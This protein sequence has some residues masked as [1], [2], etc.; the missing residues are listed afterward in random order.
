MVGILVTFLLC[1]LPYEVFLTYQTFNPSP[2]TSTS[3]R[4][5]HLTAYLFAMANTLMNPILFY[6]L[7]KEYLTDQLPSF[8]KVGRWLFILPLISNHPDTALRSATF[9]SEATSFSSKSTP[10]RKLPCR[11]FSLDISWTDPLP[12]NLISWCLVCIRVYQYRLL[13]IHS[14]FAVTL[15]TKQGVHNSKNLRTPSRKSE[16]NPKIW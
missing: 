8:P 6:R 5:A 2:L 10:R 9:S 14:P 11:T 3:T 1:W 15:Y 7:D 13:T 4:R 16:K 12:P